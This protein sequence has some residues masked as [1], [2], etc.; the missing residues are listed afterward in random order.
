MICFGS[1]IIDSEL[2]S[3]KVRVTLYSGNKHLHQVS[4]NMRQPQF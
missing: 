3:A 1:G 2:H 4:L